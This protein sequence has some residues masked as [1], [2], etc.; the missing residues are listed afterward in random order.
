MKSKQSAALESYLAQLLEPQAAKSALENIQER[1]RDTALESTKKADLKPISQAIELLESA[2]HSVG[3][4]IVKPRLSTEGSVVDAKPEKLPEQNHEAA[5]PEPTVLSNPV[6]KSHLERLLSRVSETTVAANV[7][8]AVEPAISKTSTP[9]KTDPSPAIETDVRT[10]SIEDVVGHQQPIL[11][12]TSIDEFRAQLPEGFQALIFFVGKLQLAMPLH[13]LGGI[14]K[15][16]DEPTPIFGSPPWF[17]GLLHTNT[18]SLQVIDTGMYLFNERYTPDLIESY[19]YI[20]RLGDSPWGLLVTELCTTKVLTH[21]EI[22]WF[23]NDNGRP[24]IAGIVKEEKC[25]L[26]NAPALMARFQNE[27]QKK[28]AKVKKTTMLDKKS[29]PKSGAVARRHQNDDSQNH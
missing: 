23:P 12:L 5:T 24:W 17:T 18:G 19:Q 7:S 14:V 1:S 11:P 8:T 15:K 28:P 3:K 4:I 25:A 9:A 2:P 27:S 21:D 26:L 16:V 13:L 6:L 29:A 20:I 22:R 10:P